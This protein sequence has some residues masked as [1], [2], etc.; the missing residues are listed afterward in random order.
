MPP[1]AMRWRGFKHRGPKGFSRAPPTNTMDN[2]MVALV[3]P[4][5]GED[6]GSVTLRTSGSSPGCIQAL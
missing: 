1:I 2:V 5:L 6:S 3:G 4:P